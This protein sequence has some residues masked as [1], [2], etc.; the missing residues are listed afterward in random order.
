MSRVLFTLRFW[1]DAAE[2]SVK[3]F[4]QGALAVW[5]V[6][7]SPVLD[8]SIVAA[9]WAGAATALLSVL[10]SVASA[11][12]SGMSPASIVPPGIQ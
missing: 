4:A 8:A 11:N 12:V 2:R 10:T 9:L 1:A 7:T 5:A 3:S 6:G